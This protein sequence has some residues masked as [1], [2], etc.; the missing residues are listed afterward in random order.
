MNWPSTD[1]RKLKYRGVPLDQLSDH[2]LEQ[3]RQHVAQVLRSINA[4]MADR[5]LWRTDDGPSA[6]AEK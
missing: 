6:Q 3:A 1:P 4:V 2:D 5:D